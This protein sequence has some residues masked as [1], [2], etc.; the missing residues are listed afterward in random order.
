[1]SAAVDPRLRS[2][3]PCQK[4][5]VGRGLVAIAGVAAVCHL[6]ADPVRVSQ[7]RCRCSFPP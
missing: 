5:I 2:I 3:Y 6:L 7:L 4:Q 1:M